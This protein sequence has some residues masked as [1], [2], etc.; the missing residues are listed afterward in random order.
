[1]NLGTIPESHPD[2]V[3]YVRVHSTHMIE[4]FNTIYQPNLGGMQGIQLE[5]QLGSSLSNAKLQNNLIIAKGPGI[6]MSYSIAIGV[7]RQA[8]NTID[9]VLV[10]HN[11]IDFSGAYGPVYLP[12][13][14]SNLAF[15]DNVNLQTG[16]RIASP[17]GTTSSDVVQVTATPPV[18]AA[19][20]GIKIGLTVRLNEIALVNGL[21]VLVLNTGGVAMFDGGSGTDTLHFTY[22]VASTD[23]AV[24]V[25]ATSALILPGGSF[26]R[27]RAGNDLNFA[28]IARTFPDV[29]VRTGA[30]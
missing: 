25:L 3:Q 10:G 7:D 15:V 27:D 22:T 14:G 4:A 28:D 11:Y 1:V 30:R 5:A 20:P 16:T 24:A 6:R 13:S 23:K 29:A 19:E 9:G 26:V 8:G 18:A 21:P 17:S 12:P 2:A